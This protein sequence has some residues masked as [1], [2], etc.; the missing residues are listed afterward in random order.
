MI[1]FVIEMWADELTLLPAMRYNLNVSEIKEK[2]MKKLFALV[3]LLALTTA[4]ASYAAGT[5]TES[6]VNKYTSGVA[7]KEQQMKNEA[8][9]RQQAREAQKAEFQKKVEADKAAREARQAEFN[10]KIQDQQAANEA[11]R[12]EFQ[13]KVEADKKAREARQA[14]TDKKIQQKKEAWNT[15]MGK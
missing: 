14:E 12:A 13:K 8:A 15:L 10:K 5:Y 4:G 2:I 9:A 1:L 7:K 11:K 6:V 3:A